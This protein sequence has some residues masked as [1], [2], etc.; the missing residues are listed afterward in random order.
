MA[1]LYLIVEIRPRPEHAR[2]VRSILA[3]MIEA[4]R[5]EAGCDLYDLV[6]DPA[7]PSVWVMVEKWSSRAAWE[8]HM[9]APHNVEGNARLDG[10]LVE[11][12]RLRFLDPA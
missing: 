2:E 4:T 12:A 11:P 1:A 3:G 10:L 6:V 9:V 5:R 7:D 8:A